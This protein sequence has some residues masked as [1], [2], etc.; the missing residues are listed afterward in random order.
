[1]EKWGMSSFFGLCGIRG[2][3]LWNA[4]FYPLSLTTLLYI[5]SFVTMLLSPKKPRK[6]ANVCGHLFWCLKNSIRG[7]LERMTSLTSNVLAWR[8]Y[9]V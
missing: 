4:V 7:F 9:V 2:D 3:H 1:M 8:N 6:E 5:G